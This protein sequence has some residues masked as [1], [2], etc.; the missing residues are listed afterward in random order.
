M[1]WDQLSSSIPCCQATDSF[2]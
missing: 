2:T 1:T